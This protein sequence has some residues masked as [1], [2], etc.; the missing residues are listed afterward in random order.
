MSGTDETPEDQPV[1]AG[2]ATAPIP[3]LGPVEPPVDNEGP[4]AAGALIADGRF[5]LVAAHGAPGHLQFWQAFD[6]A[7][8]RMVALTLVDP[9]ESLPVDRVNE[10]LSL[11]VRQRGLDM[12]GI[13]AVREVFHT[14]RFGVVVSDWVPG[15]TLRQIADTNPSPLGVAG[16]MQSLA[17]AAEAA[18]RA[19]LALSIDHPA[20]VR[21]STDGNAVLAFPGT[22]PEATPREDLRGIGAAFYALLVDRW[23]AQGPTPVGWTAVDVDAAGRPQEPAAIDPD[24]P[25]LISAAAAGLVRE[26]GITSAATLM[27][28]LRQA[29]A[30][31][32]GGQDDAGGAPPPAAVPGGYAGFGNVGPEQQAEAA[33]RQLVR[34]TLLA[35]AAIMVVAV[36]AV[37]SS[38]TDVLDTDSGPALDAERLGLNATTEVAAP[39]TSPTMRAAAADAPIDIAEAAVFAPGGSPDNP[40]DAGKAVDRDPATAWTTDTY[41]DAVPFPTFKEGLGLSIK[42]R[43][44]AILSAVT[45]DL[46][47]SGTVI[48]IRSATTGA[49]GALADTTELSPPVP[50]QPGH[51]RIAVPAAAATSN[52]VVWIS[53]LGTMDGKSRTEISEVRLIAAAPPA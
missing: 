44:P 20:R 35:A 36:V 51:N 43:Q 11:T 17:V 4:F 10:V 7:A 28:L 14:G 46:A 26:G 25:F 1:D 48:Q 19:G 39:P 31:V 38:L 23:P 16:A 27:T 42:L 49:P 8:G 33:K 53:T 41:R 40:G 5:R 24:I 37:V 2:E 6:F 21:I 3:G 22:T 52:V 50:V 32:A 45:V 9:R 12:P 13:A 29:R 34:V 15:G 30:D 47:S 18:H